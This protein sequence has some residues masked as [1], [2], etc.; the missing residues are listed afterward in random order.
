M[1]TRASVRH[2]QA[3]LRLTYTEQSL[4]Y[5]EDAE[6]DWTLVTPSAL[7]NVFREIGAVDRVAR[8]MADDAEVET[9]DVPVDLGAEAHA[10]TT[11]FLLRSHQWRQLVPIQVHQVQFGSPLQV[12]LGLA[13][14]ISPARVIRGIID[15]YATLH[16]VRAR[17]HA[18]QAVERA[19]ELAAEVESVRYEQELIRLGAR[20]V[21]NGGGREIWTLNQARLESLDVYLGEDEPPQLEAA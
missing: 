11:R 4:S 9:F 2:E 1:A 15:L 18:D 17:I 8:W 3:Y 12:V 14:A 13:S 10:S 20:T 16:S 21:R 6:A 19:R 7:E 5:F